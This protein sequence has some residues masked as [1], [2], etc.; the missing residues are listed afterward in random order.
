MV[1]QHIEGIQV[2]AQGL[3]EL[4]TDVVF[5]GGAVAE[6]YATGQASEEARVSDDIDCVIEISTRK[7]Y[8]TLERLLESKGFQHDTTAGVPVC[9][10]I[11]DRIVVDIMPTNIEILGFSNKWYVLGIENKI[12]QNLP[13]GTIINIFPPEI[14][15]AS[16]FEALKNRGTNDLRQSHDFEDIIYVLDNNPDISAILSSSPEPVKQYLKEQFEILNKRD[17][18]LEVIECALP[19]SAGEDSVEKIIATLKF[20]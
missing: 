8:S 7:E 5:I 18:I 13:D 14:F 16:K 9:R 17:D 10:W 15:L 3:G 6:F 2:I 1:R 12:A 20:E 19:Y 11:F 4:L